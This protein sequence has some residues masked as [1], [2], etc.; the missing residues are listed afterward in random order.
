YGK[1]APKIAGALKQLPDP[2]AARR[3]LTAN[4]SLRLEVD[5]QAVELSGEDVEIRLAAKP[6]WSAAQG[7]A[8][9]VVLN[10]ELTDELREEGMIRELIHHVQALR[11]AHQLEYEAR[12]AL[13]IGAAPPFAEMIRRWESMLRAECLAEKVEYASDAGGG[14]SV[15]IDGEPVRLA[16]AVVGE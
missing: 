4:G 10:T 5:G 9:V 14:E 12:I 8:G 16:L 3:D 13:T 15:T 2:A 11:K 1:L 7:R 6:G